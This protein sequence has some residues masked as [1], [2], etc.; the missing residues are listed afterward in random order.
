MASE[1]KNLIGVDIGSTSIKVCEIKESRGGRKLVNFGFHPLPP[2]TIVNGEIMNSGAVVEGLEKLFHKA[3]RRNVALR[4]SGHGVIIKKIAVPLMTPAEL[5]E[6][7]GWE[8]EQHIPFDLAEVH[9]DYQVLHRRETEGQMDVLLVA[10]KRE[11]I[12]D[13]QNIALEARLKP[14]VVD[15]D[16]FTVQNVFEEGY[17]KPAPGETVVLI[18][19]GASLTTVNI[20]AGGTTAFTRDIANGGLAITEEIQ[21]TLSIGRE[22][23]EAYKLGGEGRGIVPREVPD[24]IQQV[25]EQLA[26]EVQRS[27]DFYLAT[28][29]E[30]DLSRIYVSGGTA[31]IRGL[32][33]AIAERTGVPVDVLDPLRVASR[34][35]KLDPAVLQGRTAQAVVAVG[36]ALRKEKERREA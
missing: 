32:R 30:S 35:A 31:N 16:A 34:D 13:L 1:G 18:H 24:I 33:D 21:R 10:A 36:L 20:L 3:R 7:I 5:Q 11:E 26:G 4:A 17:G 8:A 27:L 12:S 29:G 15:L 22:E 2:D 14:M 28:T 9:I 19:V 6:Q 25:V 23:A